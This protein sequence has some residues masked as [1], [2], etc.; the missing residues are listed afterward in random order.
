M[1]VTGVVAGVVDS[2][3]DRAIAPGY[4]VVGFNARKHFWPADAPAGALRGRVAVVTGANSG[5]G[6]AAAVGLAELG[7]AV[8]LVVRDTAKGDKAREDVLAAVPGADVRVD[9]CDV[10]DLVDVRKFAEGFDGPLDVLVHNAGVLPPKRME[11]DQGHE[12]ALA[13]AVLGP[14]LLTDLLSPALRA[15]ADGRV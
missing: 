11:T 9:R 1:T 13:T 6:K 3:L 10:S 7:A 12:V 5:L 14:F 4:S 15:S 8:R 2:V